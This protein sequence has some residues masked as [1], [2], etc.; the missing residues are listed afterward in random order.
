[1][2][3]QKVVHEM[4]IAALFIIDKKWKQPKCPSTGKWINKIWYYHTMEQFSAIERNEVLIHSVT[5]MNLENML[6]EIS[7]IQKTTYV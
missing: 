2:S 5:W 4:S 3:T 7:Q 6:S 1:M